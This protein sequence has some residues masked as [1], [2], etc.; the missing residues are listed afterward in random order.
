MESRKYKLYHEYGFDSRQHLEHY[1]SD[2]T[3][4]IFEEDFL[5]FP[6]KN[7]RK[8]FTEGH[9]EGDVLVD[10]SIGSMIHHLYSAC[11]FFNY[12]IVLKMRDRC[13]LELK[14][15]VDSRTG[16]FSWCHA[17]KLQVEIEGK[18]DLLLEKEEKMRSAIEHVV[19]C[20]LEKENMVDPIVLPPADCVI[21][22]WLLDVISKNQ[23]EYMKYIKKFSRLLKPEG[24]IIIIGSVDATYF[25]VG[26]DKLHI[27]SYN[28]DFARNAIVGAGFVIDHCEVMK[29]T[30]ESDLSDFKGVIFIAA[31]KEK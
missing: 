17:A 31:H 9:I 26:K 15:W 24:H 5:I 1:F 14:R 7:L 2:S 29:R 21:S 12:F 3:D 18:S 27:F 13:I 6:I 22:A 19:K 20:D 8:A 25:T 16:A 10:L 11:D 23:D 28:E 4:M 30:V